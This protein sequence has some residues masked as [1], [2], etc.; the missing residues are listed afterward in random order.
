[1]QEA[2]HDNAEGLAAAELRRAF[3]ID[4]DLS[5]FGRGAS[6]AGFALGREVAIVAKLAGSSKVWELVGTNK[7]T[8]QFWDSVSIESRGR[9]EQTAA[10]IEAGVRCPSARPV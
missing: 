7:G 6:E 3:L 10:N 2:I 4:S 9:L 1:M 5:T 8:N